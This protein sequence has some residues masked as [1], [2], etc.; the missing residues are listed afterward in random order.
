MKSADGATVTSS[1]QTAAAMKVIGVKIKPMAMA[2]CILADRDIYEG[3]WLNDKANGYG[4]Y[5]HY[6]GTVYEGYWKNDK[7]DG[8]GCEKWSNGCYYI[9]NYLLGLK[10]GEGTLTFPDGSRYEV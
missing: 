7:Q 3:Q 4:T 1:G 9:G 10:S 6:N 5:T 2:N 8:S